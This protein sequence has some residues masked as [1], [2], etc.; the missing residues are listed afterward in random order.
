MTRLSGRRRVIRATR[1]LWG[2]VL[3]AEILRAEVLRGDVPTDEA[4][5]GEVLTGGVVL[6][7]VLL[8]DASMPDMVTSPQCIDEK[9]FWQPNLN[10]CLRHR[11]HPL[12]SARPV[13]SGD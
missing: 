4:L 2:E 5:V 10:G 7:D 3:S 6:A 12:A 11:N 13:A 1:T 9:S 8:G